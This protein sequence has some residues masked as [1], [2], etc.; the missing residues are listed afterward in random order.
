LKLPN[1]DRA[2][3]N[4][5]KLRDYLL[6]PQH[7]IGRFKA[8]FFASL[9]YSQGD[10]VRLESDFRRQ[11]LMKEAGPGKKTKYGRKYE[12]HAN[13]VGPNGRSA[14]VVSVWIIV[15]TEDFPRFVTAYPGGGR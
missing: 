15:A 3:I 8:V 9:G 12:I 13:L 14:E 6:S 1:I 5:E 4:P 2:L 7:P 10:W 11:H